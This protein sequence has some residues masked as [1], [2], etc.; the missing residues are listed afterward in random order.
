MAIWIDRKYLSLVSSQLSN[1]KW[2]NHNL[3]NFRCPVCGDSKKSTTKSRGYVYRKG[4]D[5]FF[6]CHN[7]NRGMSIYNLLKTLDPQ[8]A[9]DYQMERFKEGENGHSNFPKPVVE[10]KE[11]FKPKKNPYEL[12]EKIMIPVSNLPEKHFAKELLKDRCFPKESLKRVFFL[13]KLD[14][15]ERFMPKYKGKL[16]PEP[17][18]V[19]PLI[20]RKGNI[21]GFSCREINQTGL[22]YITL[23]VVE[24]APTIFGLY[25]LNMNE[26]VHVLEGAADSIFLPNAIAVSGSDFHKVAKLIPQNN[27][28][29]IFDNEPRNKEI[30]LKMDQVIQNGWQ[31][32]IWPDGFKYK[33]IN[34]CIMR[35]MTEA[36]VKEMVNE[37]VFQGMKAKLRFTFW[38]R[39]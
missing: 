10:F 30:V 39:R 32:F 29:I 38:K 13:E 1:F 16:K 18:I 14:T 26:H 34:D 25:E 35:G 19:F 20:S 15:L 21:I 37:N 27:S 17:R 3:A 5:L 11:T 12:L 33:D 8:I 24:A 23:K 9:K 4:N 2:K 7:C 28:T 22:R 36:E 31:V 6:K